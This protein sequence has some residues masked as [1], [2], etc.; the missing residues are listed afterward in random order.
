MIKRLSIL[1]FVI[2]LVGCKSK[3]Q[4][5]AEQPQEIKVPLWVSSRPNNGFKYVG[6]G[7]AEKSKGPGYQME[8]KKAAL[9]DLASEIKTNISSNS[10]LYTVQNNNNF[11]ENFNSLIKLSNTDNLEGYQLIDAYENDKQYWVYYQLDKQEYA[12]LKAKKKLQTINRAAALIA[13]SFT[14]ELNK[15]FSA[16]LKKRIQAFGV[17]TPYLSEEIVFDES[18]TN[19]IKTVF[20]LT[21]RIQQQLQSI[22]TDFGSEPPSLKPYQA[23]YSPLSYRL[24]IN[25][26]AALQNFPFLVSS[27]DDRVSV[28]G[29]AVTNNRGN[30]AIKVNHV[31]PIEQQVGF[32]LQPDIKSLMGTDSVGLAGI[33]LLGQFISTGALKVNATVRAI[34]VF[35]QCEEK[36]FGVSTGASTIENA[37]RERFAGDEIRVVDDRALA[38][39]IIEVS[40]DTKEDISSSVLTQ[41]Y[42]LRLANLNIQI[43]LK[44]EGGQDVLYKNQVSDIFGYANDLVNAGLNAYQ[45]PKLEAKFG[46]ALFFLKRKVLVY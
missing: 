40:S 46:E 12:D 1:F 26:T 27:D 35:I 39:Y 9:Y 44:S 42:K 5:V 28:Q 13:S 16:S 36:N 38:D 20:D 6:I 31:E 45:S 32:S 8:A 33:T 10:V 15:D 14:D 25:N 18:Q 21:S 41:Y 23:S 2:V 4:V 19:G 7:F 3:Q 37:V 34:T 22:T 30:I 43:T 11:N 17:L 29:Y 24:L